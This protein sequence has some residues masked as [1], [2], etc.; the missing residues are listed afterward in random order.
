M[1]SG[2]LNATTGKTVMKHIAQEEIL[3]AVL[4]M[5]KQQKLERW[6]DLIEKCGHVS[7]IRNLENWEDEML[8]FPLSQLYMGHTPFL[9]AA[10]DPV[11]REMG[12]INTASSAMRFFNLTKNEL[13]EFTCDCGGQLSGRAMARHIRNMADPTW[14]GWVRNL[15]R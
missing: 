12:L 1:R 5:T 2:E 8:N 9:I 10:D 7:M 13:H 4:I 11:F 15:F 3:S 14:R 6:A